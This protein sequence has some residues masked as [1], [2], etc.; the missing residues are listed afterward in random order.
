[1][2]TRKPCDT[3]KYVFEYDKHIYIY[4]YGI[5]DTWKTIVEPKHPSASLTIILCFVLDTDERFS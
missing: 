2:R 5:I 4:V 3:Y 1:M